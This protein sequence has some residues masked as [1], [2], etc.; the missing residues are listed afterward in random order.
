MS[1][2][3]GSTPARP[4]TV[5]RGM[6][7]VASPLLVTEKLPGMVPAGA[8]VGPVPEETAVLANV[9]MWQVPGP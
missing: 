3:L 7:Y 1:D 4:G 9:R 8:V 6:V 2:S 5:V